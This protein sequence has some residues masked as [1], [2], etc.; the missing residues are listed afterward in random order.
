MSS[1]LEMEMERSLTIIYVFI[2]VF[3]HMYDS[4]LEVDRLL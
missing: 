4:I 2:L 3:L 1:R